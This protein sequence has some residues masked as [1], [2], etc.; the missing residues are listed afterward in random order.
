ML[1]QG[2]RGTPPPVIPLWYLALRHE[3]GRVVVYVTLRPDDVGPAD[4]D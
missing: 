4:G 3:W 2:H 1:R